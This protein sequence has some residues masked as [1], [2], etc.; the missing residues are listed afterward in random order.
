M[1]NFMITYTYQIGNETKI[2]TAFTQGNSL[3]KEEL[4]EWMD[5]KL[6]KLCADGIC[7]LNLIELEG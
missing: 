4:D 7:I 3:T 6:E 5:C 2:A 1:R